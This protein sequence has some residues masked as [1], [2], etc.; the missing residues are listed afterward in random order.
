M[1]GPDPVGPS[2]A[3][4]R[5]RGRPGRREPSARSW[6]SSRSASPSG[7]S[8]HTCSPGPGFEADLASF[9]FWANDLATNGLHGFYERDFFHDYTPGYLYVLWL[10]G[11]VGKAIGRHRRPDQDPADPRRPRH[12]LARLVDGPRARRPGAA[13]AAR[14]A[15][16][17]VAEPDLL[18]RQRRSGAR[19]TRSASCSCCSACARSGATSRSGRRSSA[20]IAAAHQ[21]AARDPA[22]RSSRWSPSA[23]RCGPS[24]ERTDGGR[25]AGGSTRSGAWEARTGH[26]IRILTT[27]L[28]GYITALILCLPFGLSVL[29]VIP[30]AALRRLRPARADR[31]R[32]RRLPV[33]DR[34]RLQHLGTRPE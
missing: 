3:R 14:R 6:S 5:R 9:R 8:S 12:R 29:Q 20:V 30:N 2:E 26:P 27:G 28:A 15:L 16:V 32:R 23:V 13:G 24:P 34:Q 11:T 31:P 22:C 7:S 21:A 25:S 18:V 17:V 10:V 19:S 4:E 1:T 33:P